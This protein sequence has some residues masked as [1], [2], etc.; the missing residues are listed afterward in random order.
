MNNIYIEKW[1]EN[2]NRKCIE[3]IHISC[4][5]ISTSVVMKCK[6]NNKLPFSLI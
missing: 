1:A 3:D 4:M 2:M 5:K 6:L